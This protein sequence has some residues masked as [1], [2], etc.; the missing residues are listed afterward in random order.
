MRPLLRASI[1]IGAFLLVPIIPFLFLGESFESQ[2]DAFLRAQAEM[3][4]VT[5]CLLVIAALAIDIF[6]PIP[7]SAISTY[8]GG[9][10]GTGLATFASWIGL[11]AGSI[12]GFGLARLLGRP[13][14][15]RLA[16][17]D[18]VER[19]EQ[20]TQRFG[21]LALVLTRAL[22]I[23]AESCVLLMGATQLSWRRFMPPVVVCNFVIALTYSACGEY[24][25]K[26]DALPAAVVASGTIPLLTALAIRKWMPNW[27]PNPD[28]AISD[29]A[30]DLDNADR[31]KDPTI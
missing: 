18:D 16:G 10:L 24:F 1:L 4:S 3:S 2:V 5:H 26:L 19:I 30:R 6:L 28:E 7:S 14:A 9:V 21:P 29:S 27:V 23:L 15:V 17:A 13:F 25:Q 20:F 22:P 8:A 11:T 31:A 12:V